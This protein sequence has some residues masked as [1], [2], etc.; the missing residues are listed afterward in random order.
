M[1]KPRIRS[2]FALKDLTAR[3]G[4]KTNKSGSVMG[5]DTNVLLEIEARIREMKE[6]TK[7]ELSGIREE[8]AKITATLIRIQ[9]TSGG[10]FGQ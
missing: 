7:E 6:A 4:G 5:E 9:K 1:K 2:G 10:G 3:R 8:L